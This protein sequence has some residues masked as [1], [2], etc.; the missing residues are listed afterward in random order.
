M[1]IAPAPTG[2]DSPSGGVILA[3]TPVGTRLGSRVYTTDASGLKTAVRVV[4][5]PFAG[6]HVSFFSYRL[7]PVLLFSHLTD[8]P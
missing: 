1:G 8:T 4:S 5:P 2:G 3:E 7:Q 6:P